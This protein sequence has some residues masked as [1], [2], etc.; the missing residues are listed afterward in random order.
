M[1]EKACEGANDESCY[2]LSGIYMEGYEKGNI[3][4]DMKR[5]FEFA[6]KACNLDNMYAC[7]NLSMMYRTGDGVEK[8]EELAKKFKTKAKELQDERL[9]QQQLAFQQGLSPT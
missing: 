9:K 7:N 1:L 3:V 2:H 6:V 8:N 4:K 5:S